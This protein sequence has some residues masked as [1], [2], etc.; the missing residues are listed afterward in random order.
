MSWCRIHLLKK[1]Q[2]QPINKNKIAYWKSIF[3]LFLNENIVR[4]YSKEPSQLIDGLEIN[5]ISGAQTILIWTYDNMRSVQ[6]IE[7]VRDISNNLD[8]TSET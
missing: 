6:I 4:G 7:P 1:S 5:A 3:F 2:F 8:V